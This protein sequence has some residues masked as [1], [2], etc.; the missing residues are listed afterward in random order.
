[1]QLQWVA[2]GPSPERRPREPAPPDLILESDNPVRVPLGEAEEP[3]PPG[4][5]LGVEGV[6]AGHPQLGASPRYPH[7]LQCPPD[8]RC[9]D[10]AARDPCFA[11]GIGQELECPA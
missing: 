5:L 7:A 2:G 1:M 6:R 4:L 9:A 8:G 11:A 3:V 10:R